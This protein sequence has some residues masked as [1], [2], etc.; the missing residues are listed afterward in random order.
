[1]ASVKVAGADEVKVGKIICLLRNY[2]AHAAEKT[3]EP[4]NEPYFFIKPSTSIIHDGETI[5]IPSQS[6]NVH[7]EVELAVVIGKTATKVQKVR[8]MEHVSAYAVLIDVTAR[9]IQDEAKKAGRPWSAAKGFDTFAPV[10]VAMPARRVPEPHKLDI[11]LKI[12]GQFRQQGSTAQMIY[13]VPTIIE[14]VSHI[15]TLEPGDM[16]ATGTPEGVGPI[17]AGDV[18]EAGIDEVGSLKVNVA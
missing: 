17:K 5:V 1:M 6:K 15:M 7:H 4:P 14:Y 2:R 9:D 18:L 10:S 16:I 8:A 12:N 3:S 13:D 11:W